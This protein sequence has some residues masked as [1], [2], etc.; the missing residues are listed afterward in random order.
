MLFSFSKFSK[1]FFSN[2]KS[3]TKEFLHRCIS[4]ILFIDPVKLSKMKIS[5]Q[6]YLKDFLDRFGTT[7]LEDGFL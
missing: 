2:I 4:K 7:Y 1:I 5:L 6:V 3:V